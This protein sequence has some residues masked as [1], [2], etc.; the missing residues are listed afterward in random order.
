MI[1]TRAER[2]LPPASTHGEKL[3]R[4][5]CPVCFIRREECD[6]RIRER[7]AAAAAIARRLWASRSGVRV[8]AA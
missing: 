7:E 8:G 5:I 3:L 6:R 2:L 4:G 1:E